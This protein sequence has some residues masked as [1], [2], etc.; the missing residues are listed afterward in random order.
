MPRQTRGG[1]AGPRC[2]RPQPKRMSYAEAA[3]MKWL[4]FVGGEFALAALLVSLPTPLPVPSGAW[5]LL[6]TQ[7]T[8]RRLR[9]PG[10][11]AS[12]RASAATAANPCDAYS[13]RRARAAVVATQ[14]VR[15]HCPVRR[16]L[17]RRG[18]KAESC[19]LAVRWLSTPRLPMVGKA[20]WAKAVTV[21]AAAEEEA[22]EV[23]EAGVGQAH[24]VCSRRRV[25]ETGTPPQRMT[26]CLRRA[27]VVRPSEK[28]GMPARSRRRAAQCPEPQHQERRERREWPEPADG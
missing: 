9:E 13:C 22:V 16:G 2:S 10:A 4:P 8:C 6:Q 3:P 15:R 27:V 21:K 14:G 1:Q 11:C 18:M 28:Q 24:C 12:D 26:P 17:A 20:W 23:R 5:A 25:T 7:R 19:G